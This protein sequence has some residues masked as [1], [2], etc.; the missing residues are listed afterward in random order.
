MGLDPKPS[1]AW[2]PQPIVILERI[3][4]VLQD[5]LTAFELYD[6]DI[7]EDDVC[8]AD[9]FAD[10]IPRDEDDLSLATLFADLM[11]LCFSVALLV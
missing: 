1:L 8:L 2:N 6:A 4:Q 9:V 10:L 7:D 5:C 11:V 3:H